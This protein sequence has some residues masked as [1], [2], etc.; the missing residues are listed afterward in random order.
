MKNSDSKIE[1]YF[2][3]ERFYFHA[4]AWLLHI[5][6]EQVNFSALQVELNSKSWINV[7]S[8]HF[9]NEIRSIMS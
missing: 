7:A 6:W 2:P 5:A 1:M 8:E 9:H 4:G 3:T